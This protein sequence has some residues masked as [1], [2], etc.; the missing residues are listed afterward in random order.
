MEPMH[1][2]VT[3][4]FEAVVSRHSDSNVEITSSALTNPN[5][6]SSTYPQRRSGIDAGRYLDRIG[7]F[8]NETTFSTATRTA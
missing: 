5:S 7:A 1:E 3:L 6:A 4:T 2:I 8:L